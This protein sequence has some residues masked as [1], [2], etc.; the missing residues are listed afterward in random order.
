[1]NRDKIRTELR[2]QDDLEGWA[3]Y[4]NPNTKVSKTAT[5]VFVFKDTTTVF[6]AVQ[7][8]M[9]MPI[10]GN[11]WDVVLARANYGYRDLPIPTGFLD[12]YMK[13]CEHGAS[14]TGTGVFFYNTYAMATNNK[15]A[16]YVEYKALGLN[17]KEA[18]FI[19]FK[20][21]KILFEKGDK[22][23]VSVNA[24]GRLLIK[25]PGLLV[26]L[27]PT[28]LDH[29]GLIE[30]VRPDR[31][32]LPIINA[33]KSLK[34]IVDQAQN[35]S[36]TAVMYQG[37]STQQKILTLAISKDLLYHNSRYPKVKGIHVCHR[38]ESTVQT[39]SLSNIEPCLQMLKYSGLPV[40]VYR[41][42]SL[43]LSEDTPSVIELKC[44]NIA[45]HIL[46]ITGK[47]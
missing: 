17:P 7:N 40:N 2:K 28:S 10:L 9:T 42:D 29:T 33:K 26:S 6:M 38:T 34:H 31:V 8:F 35:V 43:K 24:G 32:R 4:N 22:V 41:N 16:C 47:P 15:A 13:F 21:I 25:K 36:N 27:A 39:V 19:P 3:H 5:A 30:G 46:C 14:K 44:G 1:M 12:A 20:L 37:K 11:P 45:C 18:Y 23:M